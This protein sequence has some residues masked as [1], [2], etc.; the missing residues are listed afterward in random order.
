MRTK[1]NTGTVS[2]T[3]VAQLA[4]V[5][6]S[7]V[8]RVIS[9][10]PAIS[11][12]TKHQVLCA[13]REL[14]YKSEFVKLISDDHRKT[15]LDLV[16]CPLPEQN[17]PFAL[18]FF[19]TVLQGAKDGTAGTDY[20]VQAITLPAGTTELPEHFNRNG[21]ILLGYPEEKLR[22]QL[23]TEQIPYIIASG[24]ITVGRDEALVAPD[25]FECGIQGG[26][27][28]FEQG[29]RRIGFLLPR[30]NRNRCSGFEYAFR[31]R[32]LEI[33]PSDI[34][35]VQTTDVSAFIEAIHHWI[36]EK[37]L[38]EAIVVGFN[39]AANAIETILKLN[40]IRVPENVILMS[41][42]HNPN[43]ISRP[44]LCSKPYEM[45]KLATV[46]LLERI[47][48]PDIPSSWTIVPMTLEGTQINNKKGEK[49][50]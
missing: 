22:R 43:R 15:T 50:K 29:C 48:H 1:R 24:D 19:S 6:Q 4:G 44:C 35:F 33:R 31:T 30:H 38:P 32:G 14:G 13:L 8:S 21:I 12:S 7:T 36:T 3:D 49:Y 16:M 10:H 23:K 27:Y 18:D 39:D 46:R 17:D 9:R 37:D 45:G 28:L 20:L 47:Q 25:N 42:D 40:G 41:F 26:K 5:S 11:E 2:M 34:R